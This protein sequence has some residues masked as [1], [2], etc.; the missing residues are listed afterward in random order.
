ML[1]A[2]SES[3]RC[4]VRV[5]CLKCR[6]AR[7]LVYRDLERIADAKGLAFS[8]WNKRTRCKLT[9]RCDGWNVFGYCEGLWV[10]HLYNEA[11][12]DRWDEMDRRHEE[13]DRLLLAKLLRDGKNDRERKKAATRH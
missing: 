11:Q 9:S 4:S 5:R 8:L 13:H 6:E 2:Y 12:T 1:R 3:T 10:Y 7:D